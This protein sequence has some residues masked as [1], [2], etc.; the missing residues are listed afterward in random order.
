M[1]EGGKTPLLSSD[2]L[3]ELG[4]QLVLYPL[5]GLYAAARSIRLIYQKLHIDQSTI[6]AEDHL[7]T[8][9]EFNGLIGVDEKYTQAQRFG[10]DPA[11]P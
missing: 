7:M 3:A 1:I 4:F 5:S 2:E 9:P 8:F 11:N 6:G 10:V